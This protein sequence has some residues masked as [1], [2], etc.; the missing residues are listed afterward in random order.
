MSEAFESLVREL[1]GA[2]LEE[3]RRSVAAEMKDRRL[4]SAIRIEDIHPRMSAEEKRQAMAEIA[5]A[6]QGGEDA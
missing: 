5:R 4:K 1:D 3:L 6:L 2:A